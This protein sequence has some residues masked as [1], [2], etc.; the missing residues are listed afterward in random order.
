VYVNA[1]TLRDEDGDRGAGDHA[2]VVTGVDDV[3]G[4]VH[5]N[6]SAPDDG[7]DEQVPLAT[8]EAA[9]SAGGHGMT[10]AG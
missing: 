10:V 9:W 8:F 1:A 3:A 7:R 5:L 4:V 2:V 6:D